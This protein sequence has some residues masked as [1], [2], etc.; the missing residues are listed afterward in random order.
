[1]KSRGGGLPTFQ[2]ILVYRETARAAQ[3]YLVAATYWRRLPSRRGFF[4]APWERHT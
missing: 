3:W 2:L 4:R 1:M